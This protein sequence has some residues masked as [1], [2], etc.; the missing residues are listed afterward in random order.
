MSRRKFRLDTRAFS[1]EVMKAEYTFDLV[2][3]TAVE[4]AEKAGDGYYYH[5]ELGHKRAL[6]MVWAGDYK[7]RKDDYDNNTLLK[8]AYP[9]KVVT[10]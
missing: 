7:A 8:A 3:D 6:G 9:L 1:D 2:K 10:K 5:Y 4:I